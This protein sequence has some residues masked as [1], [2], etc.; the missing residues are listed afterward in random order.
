[1]KTVVT[2][3]LLIFGHLTHAQLFDHPERMSLVSSGVHNIYNLNKDSAQYYIS[4]VEAELGKHPAVP[5]MRALKVLWENIPLVTVDSVFKTFSGELREVIKLSATLDGGR[6]THPE[7]IFFEMSARGLLAEYY[8]D[9]GHYMKA[10]GEA[11]KAYDLVKKGFELSDKIP[12][13]LLTTGV[14][15]YFRE[16]YPEKYPAFKPLLWFFRGGD[17][18]LGLKQIDEATKKAVLTNVEAHV[19][20]AY[21]YLRYEYEP[22]KAQKY[23]WSLTREY[24]QN[25]YMKTKLL[26]S[27][28]TGEDIRQAPLQMINDLKLSKRPYYKLAGASFQGIY[29]EKVEQ[30]SQAAI[31]S[32]QATI[33]YWKSIPDYGEFYRDLAYLGLGRVYLQRKESDLARA[34]LEWVI[35]ESDAESLIKEAEMLLDSLE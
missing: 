30:N 24:P 15:N 11:G 21:I 7:A 31:A 29:L 18:K 8:A 35:D 25:L 3:I 13:F 32:Y 26:E 34:N 17:V 27:L 28:L 20:M 4:R 22:A 14:Y 2:A 19:Y 12:E 33:E 10:I 5:M 16:K 1:M 6:Q 9:E 23:L